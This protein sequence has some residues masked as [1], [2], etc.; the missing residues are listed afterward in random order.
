MLKR[1]RQFVEDGVEGIAANHMGSSSS[2]TGTGS[3]DTFDP[4]L[5]RR[6]ILK[7]KQANNLNNAWKDAKALT[8]TGK[9]G[10]K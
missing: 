7:R 9:R 3:I 10:T 2:T 1:F 4:L 5:K 6:D 8:T